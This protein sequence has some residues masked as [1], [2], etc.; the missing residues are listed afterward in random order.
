VRAPRD[1][2]EVAEWF[3][4]EANGFGGVV[5]AAFIEHERTVLPPER[6]LGVW[7]GGRCVATS[8]TY[9]FELTLPGGGAVSV[10]GVC[11]VSVLPGHRRHGHLTRMMRHLHDE[12]RTR[13]DVAMVLTASDGSIYQR[14]GYGIATTHAVWTLD[15]G[16][17][18]LR[19]EPVLDLR[20]EMVV[21]V[22]GAEPLAELWERTRHLRPGTLS[23]SVEWWRCIVGT[24]EGWKG[25]GTVFTL[26]LRDGDGQVRG[27][28]AYRVKHGH[29]RGVQDWTVEP[30]DVL[31]DDPEVEALVW[32]ELARLDHVRTIAPRLRPSDDALR[33]R[34]VDA[35]QL[36]VEAA[37]DLLWVCPLDVAGLLG[38]RAYATD[39]DVVLAVEDDFDSE[40]DGTYRLR[41]VAGEVTCHAVEDLT[42]D[43]RLSSWALGAAVLGGTTFEVLAIAGHVD[44]RK[45]GALAAAGTAFRTPVAPFNSTFF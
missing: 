40:V 39:V 45:E 11:D 43:L 22:D 33:W 12:A 17:L 29:D 19:Q 30:L 3:G 32:L 14:F 10:A 16:G 37:V 44:E 20:P 15:V 9:P 2:A 42:P 18:R 25:G 35:R 24:F 8:G 6:M 1:E 27:G 38:A 34:L 36:K 7:I 23:R 26:L 21:G 28:A 5:E 41:S 31:A 13:G 4:A